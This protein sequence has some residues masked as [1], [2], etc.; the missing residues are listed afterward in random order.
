MYI[1]K[2]EIVPQIA[3]S[4]FLPISSAL[5][6]ASVLKGVL[7]KPDDIYG[8]SCTDKTSDSS[9][10]DKILEAIDE[11]SQTGNQDTSLDGIEK[12]C[13]NLT[14]LPQ[15]AALSAVIARVCEIVKRE[16]ARRK[17]VFKKSII[18]SNS[19]FEK[20]GSSVNDCDYSY[21]LLPNESNGESTQIEK[22]I[23]E[24]G[25]A[26]RREAE[27]IIQ[28]LTDCIITIII[29]YF[30]LSL[31]LFLNTFLFSFGINV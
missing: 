2:H 25:I 31:I 16:L 9:E 15:S 29:C 3:S 8:E 4:F 28:Q 6:V 19:F 20:K 30:I 22:D 11:L 1:F 18:V 12:L 5:T 10:S 13:E 27:K 21:T 7:E 17:R 23:D 14:F 24:S 26:F